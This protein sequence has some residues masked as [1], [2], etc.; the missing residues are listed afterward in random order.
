MVKK[1]KNRL[2]S[3]TIKIKGVNKAS[4]R[5]KPKKSLRKISRPA[6]KIKSKSLTKAGKKKA[7]DQFPIISIVI[8]N[9]NGE[10]FLK[11]C[12]SSVFST[13]YPK[14]K[15]D[16]I[17]LDNASVDNSVKLV[18]E[19]Y[20]KAR[21]F[22]NNVNN[23]CKAN[24]IGIQEAKGEYIVLLNNDT[25]VTHNWLKGLLQTIQQDPKIGAVGGKILFENGKINST[26]HQEY[27]NFYWGDRG[28]KE[29]DKEQ[30]DKTEEM[31]SLCGVAVMYRRKCFEH[32][33][34]FDE[35]FV[36]YVED[37][38]LAHRCRERG[39]KIVYTPKSVVYHFNHGTSYV[40]N[41]DDPDKVEKRFVER[42]RLLFIAKHFP[43]KLADALSTS[44]F[45]YIDK[46]YDLLYDNLGILLMKLIESHK[47]AKVRSVLSDF[48]TNFKKIISFEKDLVNVQTQLKE[49]LA[50]LKKW[51]NIREQELKSKDNKIADLK[52]E[53][54]YTSQTVEKELKSQLSSQAKQEKENKQLMAL[55][56][57][58]FQKQEKLFLSENKKLVSTYKEELQKQDKLHFTDKQQRELLVE[59]QLKEVK[60]RYTG[61]ITDLKESFAKESQKQDTARL[62]LKDEKKQLELSMQNKLKEINDTNRI[63][64]NELK[65]TF[66]EEFNKQEKQFL[67]EKRKLEKSI[68]LQLKETEKQLKDKDLQLKKKDNSQKQLKKELEN[69]FKKERIQLKN[70][71]KVLSNKSKKHKNEISN[72]KERLSKKD[73][74]I[75]QNKQ[76]HDKQLNDGLR[77]LHQF[78]YQNKEL[79]EDAKKLK[80]DLF[81]LQKLETELRHQILEKN[82]ELVGVKQDYEERFSEKFLDFSNQVIEKKMEIKNI[83]DEKNVLDNE[84]EFLKSE[85]NKKSQELKTIKASIFYE[86][87][88]LKQSLFT[89]MNR[90]N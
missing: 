35:D 39:W 43:E 9:H 69:S 88:L 78:R 22:V 45:F 75:L 20:K 28:Y 31:T 23:Y 32:V 26:G 37:V 66:K 89:R 56:E 53:L 65:E 13:N 48:F 60:E 77:E 81:N 19:K 73:I 6:A 18:K 25:Q 85:L 72:L 2:K 27:P 90:K 10:K 16:V 63:F 11:K 7:I 51:L 57:K 52:R 4:K 64:K 76:S 86:M 82:T 46:N 21:I 67:E 70:Q 55:R 36:M 50:Q 3:K 17:F 54:K 74:E 68:D 62:A 84:N 40:L 1:I 29:T 59:K 61:L 47:P 14:D 87:Y 34:L 41:P 49:Q 44:A 12:L 15:L 24:N 33:G 38:D 58:E 83:H 30:Y 5:S 42:N 71:I 8:V 79:K 80:Q